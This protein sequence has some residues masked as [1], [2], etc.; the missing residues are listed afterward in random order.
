MKKCVPSTHDSL[1]VAVA[2]PWLV[3]GAWL[4]GRAL[5]IRTWDMG[6]EYGNRH[7]YGIK[8]K[9]KYVKPRTKAC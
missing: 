5:R 9:A 7:T 3:V 4:G 1:V 2:L 8:I 6:R